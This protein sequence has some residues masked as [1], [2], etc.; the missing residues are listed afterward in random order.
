MVQERLKSDTRLFI[1]HSEWSEVVLH[2]CPLSAPQPNE[3]P[4]GGDT[5]WEAIV[6]CHCELLLKH[7]FIPPHA[8]FDCLASCL[9]TIKFL[10]AKWKTVKSEK[11]VKLKLRNSLAEELLEKYWLYF[12]MFYITTL[13]HL[14]ALYLDHWDI[15]KTVSPTDVKCT[16]REFLFILGT[17]LLKCQ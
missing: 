7:S 11:T 12:R 6:T 1:C 15:C 16:I 5:L 2:V 13:S 14:F 17:E 3:P 10:E 9:D 4:W 8:T